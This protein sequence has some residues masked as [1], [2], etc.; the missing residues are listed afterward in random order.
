MSDAVR[1]KEAILRIL[2]YF[3]IFLFRGHLKIT[4]LN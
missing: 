4:Y 3:A 2:A 1:Q